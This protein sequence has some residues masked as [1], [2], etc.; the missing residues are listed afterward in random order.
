MTVRGNNTAFNAADF[1]KRLKQ[2]LDTETT[3]PDTRKQVEALAKLDPAKQGEVLK[4]FDAIVSKAELEDYKEAL[5]KIGA[6]LGANMA[7]LAQNKIVEGGATAGKAQDKTLEL[8]KTEGAKRKPAAA[9]T[10][11]EPLMDGA[12]KIADVSLKLNETA[13]A[14]ASP[15]A[16]A[17][18]EKLASRIEKA[19]Q[20]LTEQAGKAGMNFDKVERDIAKLRAMGP[21]GAAKADAMTPKLHAMLRDF[22]KALEAEAAKGA[23][24]AAPTPAAKVGVA[25]APTA[26]ASAAAVAPSAAATASPRTDFAKA[27]AEQRSISRSQSILDLINSGAPIEYILMAVMM[28]FLEDS[29]EALKQ[30]LADQM[31]KQKEVEALRNE[32]TALENN[33]P[34][35]LAKLGV[36]KIVAP[37]VQPVV[38]AVKLNALDKKE[39]K[40]EKE[41]A[42]TEADI[43]ATPPPAPVV[44]TPVEQAVASTAGD[45]LEGADKAVGSK[46]EA[47]SEDKKKAQN[48]AAKSGSAPGSV[49][50]STPAA[51]AA[52]QTTEAKDAASEQTDAKVDAKAS[53]TQTPETDTQTPTAPDAAPAPSQEELRQKRL[54]EIANELRNRGDSS[55]Q[56]QMEV[57]QLMERRSNMVELISKLMS[58]IS[59]MLSTI[60]HNI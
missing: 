60:T 38:K 58:Q 55:T 35:A 1:A 49:V 4:A 15:K 31:A 51:I 16:K 13:K 3:T 19:V 33:E 56:T 34:A 24:K 42:K 37:I 10:S 14:Q 23:P 9:K 44:A 26:A 47:S 29:D 11:S 52:K 20:T 2:V 7:F 30:K 12:E 17:A 57:Q 50:N 48:A 32:Q 41:I 21:E 40:L 22:A 43:A 54:N 28:L 6:Q 39:E 46:P 45:V 18:I 59:Q 27:A 5:E 36:P 53:N 8:R 25:P